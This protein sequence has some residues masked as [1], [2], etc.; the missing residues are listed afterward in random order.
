MTETRENLEFW[1]PGTC[2]FPIFSGCVCARMGDE[3][4]FVIIN[5]GLG[6][7]DG[8]MKAQKC[9]KHINSSTDPNQTST[10]IILWVGCC[11]VSSFFGGTKTRNATALRFGL[12]TDR[13]TL[14]KALET[15]MSWL[16]TSC[17]IHFW[18]KMTAKFGPPKTLSVINKHP[19]IP[20]PI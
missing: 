2:D 10:C 15:D 4:V 11:H 17:S 1:N 12:A 6:I 7:T 19:T 18:L 9:S 3:C 20:I 16:D 8:R 5:L 13:S 14:R